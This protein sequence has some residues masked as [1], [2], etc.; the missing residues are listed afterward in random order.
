MPRQT[1]EVDKTFASFE[2]SGCILVSRGPAFYFYLYKTTRVHG[3]QRLDHILPH[4]YIYL[5]KAQ[6]HCSILCTVQKVFVERPTIR[7]MRMGLKQVV[8]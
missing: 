4:V 3:S 2:K 8:L 1:L 7:Y 6:L 5:K